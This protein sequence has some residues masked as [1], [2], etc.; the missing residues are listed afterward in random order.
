MKNLA[1]ACAVALSLGSGAQAATITNGFT[2]AVAN[3][4][5]SSAGSHFHSSTG[6][7]F[8]N[9]AGKAEVGSYSSEEV[10]GLSEYNLTGLTASPFAFVTFDVF[11]LAG[12]FSGTNDFLYDGTISVDA[13]LG[14]NAEN[15]SDFTAASLGSVG[16]FGTA[17]LQVGDVL[18]FNITS[19]FNTSIGNSSASLGIRLTRLGAG[20]GGAVTFDDFRLTT[21]NQSTVPTVPVPASLP[22]LMAGVAGLGLLRRRKQ[23]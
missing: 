2:F 4:G 8:G 9:P 14:N 18:S 17:G 6:G 5:G 7:V 19:I 23:G 15:I 20:N 13:Y 21:D 10:R 1:L 11:A 16:T 12:L 3:G 22:L